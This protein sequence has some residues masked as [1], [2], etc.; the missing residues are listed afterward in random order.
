MMVCINGRPEILPDETRNLEDI[1]AKKGLNPEK[2]VVELN[3]QVMSR[4][5]WSSVDLQEDDQIEIVSFV[6]GG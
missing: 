3:R 5:R 4:E 1:V 2:I 6:G